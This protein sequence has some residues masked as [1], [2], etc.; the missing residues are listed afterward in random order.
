V[1]KQQNPGSPAQQTEKLLHFILRAQ[2][3]ARQ[4]AQQ[5]QGYAMVMVSIFGVLIFAMMSAY[6]TLT[7][8]STSAT[9]AHVDGT[10]TFYAAE[11]G[12]NTRANQLRQR[13]IGYAVPTGLSPGQTTAGETVMPANIANCFSIP[14]STTA[15]NTANDFEC[16]NYAFQYNNT[17]TTVEGSGGSTEATDRSKKINY[18]TFTFVADKT[19]YDPTSTVAAPVPSVIPSGQMYAGLNSQ[20]YRYTVYSTAAKIDPAD[21]SGSSQRGDAKTVLQMDFKSQI[22][23]LFQFA[24][25]YDRD[26]E[27]NST[28]PMTLTG[29]VHT[30]GNLYVQPTPITS[31]NPDINFLSKVTVTGDIYN[32]VDAQYTPTAQLSGITRVTLGATTANFPS[33][34]ASVQNP[35]DSTQISSL[36]GQV[37]N[38]GNGVQP[39]NPPAPG[40]L[41]KRNYYT[42]Q[43][44]EYF[45][46]ADLRLEMTPNSPIPFKFTAIQSGANAQGGTCTTTFTSGQDPAQNYIDPRRE[47]SIFKCTQLSVGQITSLQQPV[48]VLTRGNT[49]EEARFCAQPTDGSTDRLRDILNYASVT[50]DPTTAG[51]STVQVDKVLR[52]LQVAISAFRQPLDYLNVSAAGALPANLQTTFATLLADSTLNIGLSA[53]QIN[54]ISTASPASIAKARNS[55]FLPAPVVS[56][57]QNHGYNGNT[58]P[59]QPD[60]LLPSK[61]GEEGE[62]NSTPTP[63][64]SVVSFLLDQ[65]MGIKPANAQVLGG[66]SRG[67]YDLREWR[68]LQVI[69][70]N[71]ESLTVWNRDGRFAFLSSADLTVPAVD[72]DLA[73]ALNSSDATIAPTNPPANDAFSG[74]SVLFIR[75]LPSGSTLRSFDHLGLA[76]MDTTERG[77]VLHASVDDHLDGSVGGTPDANG[78]DSKPIYKLKPDG[79]EFT[80]GTGNKVILDYYR[81][82]PHNKATKKTQNTPYAFAVN[83]GRNL[84]GAMTVASDQAIYLQG[85]YNTVAK[86]PAAIM[87]DTITTLSVNCLSANQA[88]DPFNIPTANVNCAI[89]WWNLNPALSQPWAVGPIDSP[90]GVMYGAKPTSVNAAFLSFTNQ[91]WGNLGSG[92]G[93]GDHYYSGGLNN[94]MRF[95]E[96]WN[97]QNFNYNGSLVSLGTPLEFGGGY[98]PGGQVRTSS[99]NPSYFNPPNRNFNYDTSFN[100]FPSLPPMTPSV[101]YLQQDVFRHNR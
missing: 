84:P 63:P 16:R 75:A 95:L 67:L 49:E 101:I 8:L 38:Q 77:L 51:L 76:A 12:L 61:E 48:L 57:A 25:F 87:A 88:Q 55:C 36:L 54:T 27:I 96:N 35:L 23:P 42:N 20:Q 22:I 83:G 18:T 2:Q 26:L 91:S 70:T 19:I 86:K 71:I 58:P 9:N 33:Y 1:F 93:Y 68:E 37:A 10:N 24:A 53:A 65:I 6:L 15:S 30:N 13:F 3:L 45:G 81:L 100:A 98:R 29:R 73:A 59:T 79:S 92:R 99:I 97:G 5:E 43:I 60:I 66:S 46:K 41:R 34:N 21:P 11:S 62:T 69:Q 85:D 78:E 4:D 94:Y 44:G 28:T 56:I 50:A 90:I 74:N 31:I 17:F 80:D 52:A 39:L 32:R 82:Y 40:F 89:N 47:G 64:S 14:I 7:N 72:T